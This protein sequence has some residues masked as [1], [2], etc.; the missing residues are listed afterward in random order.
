MLAAVKL[1]IVNCNFDLPKEK[2]TSTLSK[3]RWLNFIPKLLNVSSV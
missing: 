2:I 3:A 1:I